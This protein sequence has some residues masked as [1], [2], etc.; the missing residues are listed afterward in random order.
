MTTADAQ[1]A[2][3]DLA[4][5]VHGDAPPR[6][7][8]AALAH[9]LA[10]R[11]PWLGAD[12]GTGV[13]AMNLVGGDGPLGLLSRHTRLTL[14]LARER[15]AAAAQA[16]TGAEID[17]GGSRL[18]LGAPTLRELQPHRTLYSHFVVVTAAGDDEG[19]FLAVVQAELQALGV[20]C[21]A[22]CGL[23]Q[24]VHGETGPLPGFSLMLDGLSPAHALR[25]LNAGL[26]AHRRLGCGIFVAH[27]SAA[28]VGS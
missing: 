13:H 25:I 18:R 28:A 12:A 3:V 21:Q 7:H 2:L 14:R 19:A 26:G 15:A 16:L 27:R 23:P 10:A 6:D 11:L 5:P 8:R 17:L 4:F 24:H 1:P 9:A 20:A 22:V